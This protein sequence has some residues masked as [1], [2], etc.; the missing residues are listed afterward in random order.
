MKFNLIKLQVLFLCFLA[1]TQIVAQK[2]KM[3][4]SEE[5]R[6]FEELL[7]E[8]DKQLHTGHI[9][10]GNV[11]RGLMPDRHLSVLN[12]FFKE[13][14]FK[15]ADIRTLQQIIIPAP[16]SKVSVLPR[17]TKASYAVDSIDVSHSLLRIIEPERFWNECSN[18]LAIKM[19]TDSIR[20]YVNVFNEG[21]C[22]KG[23]YKTITD[24]IA[25][26]KKR[27]KSKKKVRKLLAEFCYNI[28]RELNAVYYLIADKRELKDKNLIISSKFQFISYMANYPM[29]KSYFIQ[30][31]RRA[32]SKIK[33]DSKRP[34]IY[35]PHPTASYVLENKD[36][37]S[38]FLMI[39]DP[40]SFWEFSHYL[41]IQK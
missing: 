21:M 1:T 37:G 10:I 2:T 40:K 31:D 35:T 30:K 6:C 4:L 13:I 7:I 14:P 36:D 12:R 15:D 28:D 24:S 39:I 23:P 34:R 18:Y 22:K 19:N 20:R 25:S 5:I 26:I 8:L 27:Y 11:P 16:K 38:S 32:V 33:I 3:S 17:R 9:Y 29:P 41:I